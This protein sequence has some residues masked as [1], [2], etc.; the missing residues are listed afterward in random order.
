MI[1]WE[2]VFQIFTYSY[3]NLAQVTHYPK[4]RRQPMET[5]DGVDWKS[6]TLDWI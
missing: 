5:L 6:N 3:G 1:K 4:G 2:H